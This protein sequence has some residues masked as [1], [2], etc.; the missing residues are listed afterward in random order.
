MA[1]GRGNFDLRGTDLVVLSA[2]NTGRGQVGAGDA[3][4]GLRSAFLFTGTK[5]GRQ[6]VRSARQRANRPV[7]VPVIPHAVQ[8]GIKIGV[9]EPRAE[10][11]ELV[12]GRASPDFIPVLGHLDDV[13][14]I[15][16]LIV[17]ALWL[18]PADVVSEC[19]LTLQQESQPR[20]N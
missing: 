1:D 10:G 6:F 14:V 17:I 3:M 8:H 16:A 19:R 7:A 4:A 20:D 18:I 12:I 5:T 11:R 9:V 13:V 15:P 2:C